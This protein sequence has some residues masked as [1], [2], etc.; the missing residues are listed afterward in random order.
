MP[1][2]FW[3]SRAK[4]RARKREL[5][6]APDEL[7]RLETWVEPLT[8]GSMLPTLPLWL[9]VDLAVPLNLERSD[10]AT[11]VELRVLVLPASDRARGSGI[12]HFR[13]LFFSS[14]E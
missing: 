3:A 11:F 6:I 8:L 14:S 13:L 12:A 1:W 5:G 7:A 10:E 4:A 9:E 2:H